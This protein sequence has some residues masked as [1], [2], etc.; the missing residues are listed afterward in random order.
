MYYDYIQQ[1][2]YYDHIQQPMYYD[3]IQHLLYYDHIQQ[4][5]YYDY[6]LQPLYYD[7]INTTK[8]CIHFVGQVYFRV[9]KNNSYYGQGRLLIS[10]VSDGFPKKFWWGYGMGWALSSFIL[11]FWNFF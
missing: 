8:L 4:P 2:L 7:H 6:I 9:T 1:P 10:N 11:D 5:L 3:Y